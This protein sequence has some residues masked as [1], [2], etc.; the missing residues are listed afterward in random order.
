MSNRERLNEY[1]EREP[2]SARLYMA[3]LKLAQGTPTAKSWEVRASEDDCRKIL[4]A[5]GVSREEQ[6]EREE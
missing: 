4:D 3:L 1:L 2:M 6:E 5:L